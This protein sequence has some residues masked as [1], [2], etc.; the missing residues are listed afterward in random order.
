MTMRW[1]F[2]AVLA[3]AVLAGC[4]GVEQRVA[5]NQT[6]FDGLPVAAPARIRGGTSIWGSRRRWWR[7]RWGSRRRR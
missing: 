6:Y 1:T 7:L 4:A 3:A 2:A 5:R